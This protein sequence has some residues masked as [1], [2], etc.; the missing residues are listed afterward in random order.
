MLRQGFVE[1]TAVV[2]VQRVAEFMHRHVPKQMRRQKEERRAQRDAPRDGAAAPDGALEAD[3]DLARTADAEFV[4][5]GVDVVGEEGL[6]LLP[7]PL[8]EERADGAARRRRRIGAIDHERV[9]TAC[10][11]DHRRL[12]AEHGRLDVFDGDG[13]RHALKRHGVDA[14]G[15]PRR[16]RVREQRQIREGIGRFGRLEG[17]Q[18]RQHALDPVAA[19]RDE[20]FGGGGGG[21]DG[22]DDLDAVAVDDD[23]HPRGARADA[24][25]VGDRG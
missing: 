23:P 21:P 11:F 6:G 15:S 22:H 7:H 13:A 24:Q 8:P 9:R 1:A 5:E 2:H 19:A 10:R 14:H 4:R 25:A 12:P 3:A 17:R 20:A 18:L 16:R